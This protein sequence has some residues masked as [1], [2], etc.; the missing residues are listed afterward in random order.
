MHALHG[1]LVPHAVVTV[2]GGIGGTCIVFILTTFGSRFVLLF[3]IGLRLVTF[4]LVLLFFLIF[5][6]DDMSEEK[7]NRLVNK[8]FL[9][10]RLSNYFKNVCRY[11]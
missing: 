11:C 10:R 9:G 5:I 4:Y 8:A 6:M 3:L 7:F 2:P 1:V